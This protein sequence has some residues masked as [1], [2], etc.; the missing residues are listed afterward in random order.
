MDRIRIKDMKV[1]AYHGATLK[2]RKEGQNFYISVD[3]YVDTYEAVKNDN[4]EYAVNYASVSAF[5]KK[6]ATK[7]K[8][9]LIETLANDIARAILL[10]FKDIKK[11]EVEVKKTNAPMPVELEYVSVC[12]RKKWH[13]VILS[14]GSN[15]GDKKG[16]LDMAVATLENDDNCKDLAVS[17]YMESKPYGGVDQDDFLNGAIKLFTIYSPYE[18]LTV[19]NEIEAVAG[20]ER[21]VHWGPR[22]LDIDIVLYDD[23]VISD[24]KLVIPHFDMCNREFVLRPVAELV[25]HKLHPVSKKTMQELYKELKK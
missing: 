2:E 17:R 1:Y 18:L 25:P 14:I 24:E 10:E 19:I 6:Y 15:V 5:V 16:F 20:R 11:I 13:E 4:L 12:A 22:T 23:L 8:K 3:M 21:R 9:F 7:E